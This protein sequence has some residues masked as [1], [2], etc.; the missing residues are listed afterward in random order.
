MI[1]RA[2]VA[3]GG[4]IEG[5]EVEFVEKPLV[6]LEL[7]FYRGRSLRFFSLSTGRPGN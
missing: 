7:D 2:Q 5:A 6:Q 1:S 4:G 3:F